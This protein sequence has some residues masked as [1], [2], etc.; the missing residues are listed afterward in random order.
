MEE[1]GNRSHVELQ[2]DRE[3][4]IL[5][6]DKFPISKERINY[7]RNIRL[8]EKGL[9]RAKVINLSCIIYADT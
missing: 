5:N 9:L 7:N 4:K 1:E 3:I 2:K 8:E 6:L